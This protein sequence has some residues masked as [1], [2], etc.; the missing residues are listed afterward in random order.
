MRKPSVVI[1]G[2]GVIGLTTAWQL[3][4][5]GAEVT[6][7]DGPDQS[8]A[9]SWGSVAWSNASSKVRLGYPDHYTVLNQI[10]MAAGLDLSRQLGGSPWLHVTGAVEIVDGVDA[11]VR[12]DADL[13]RLEDFGYPAEAL[14][15][16]RF[17]ALLPGV[18]LGTDE[19]AALFPSDAWIDA[20]VLLQNLTARF[21]AAGGRLKHDEVIGADREGDV[22]TVLRLASGDTL[23]ADRFLI[24][25]GAWSG[26]VGALLG[27]DVPVLRPENPRVPGLV[28]AVTVGENPLTPILLA[29]EVIMRPFGPG[30]ALL[31]GDNHG[32][33][34]GAESSRS[35]L[36]AAAQVLLDRAAAR[37]PQFTRSAVLD[38]R[39][40]LRSIPEDGITI[41]G[42][43]SGTRNAYVLTTHSGF[44]LAPL[45]GR[46]A[47]H[48]IVSG[49]DNETLSPYRP[50]RFD[51]TRPMLDVARVDSASSTA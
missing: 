1:I 26:S 39:L 28:A 9:I 2:A 16:E 24:A 33:T 27:I 44:S 50:S 12:L 45:L 25:A 17:S 15:R 42:V 11:Q 36:F 10:G 37:A 8:R 47:A 41:A 51:T 4:G 22:L 38:V 5:E 6:V 18:R 14:D 30:R 40:G 19:A 31:A 3:V 43:P 23:T 46:L 29:P 49:R 35:D 21:A 32:H 13:A 34:I 7:V 48:E 20:P